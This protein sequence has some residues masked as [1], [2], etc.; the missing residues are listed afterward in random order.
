MSSIR[1]LKQRQRGPVE[2]SLVCLLFLLFSVCLIGTARHGTADDPPVSRNLERAQTFVEQG[3]FEQALPFLNASIRTLTSPEALYLRGHVLIK[4]GKT[5]A[6]KRDANTLIDEY[7]S[8]WRGYFLKAR[9]LLQSGSIDDQS[10]ELL[11]LLRKTVR[12]NPDHKRARKLMGRVYAALGR[13]KRALD[14]FEMVPERTRQSPRAGRMAARMAFLEGQD[15]RAADLARSVLTLVP[16]DPVAARIHSFVK[17]DVEPEVERRIRQL[18]GRRTNRS[19]DQWLSDVS[20]LIER[21]PQ[22]PHLLLFGSRTFLE[23]G[24]TD[25]ALELARRAEERGADAWTAFVLGNV[26]QKRT[27]YGTAAGWYLT[28]C[29]RRTPFGTARMRAGV[30]LS[31]DGAHE[32]AIKAFRRVFDQVALDE[33]ASERLVRSCQEAGYPV[34][35]LDRIEVLNLPSRKRETLRKQFED[36]LK[37]RREQEKE[38]LE[39]R[40]YQN[41]FY[42]IKL[43]LPDH[44]SYSL[45]AGRAQVVALFVSTSSQDRFFVVAER[46]LP[47]FDGRSTTPLKV[48][49]KLREY[50]ISTFLL[51]DTQLQFQR[52]KEHTTFDRPAVEY[53]FR[54]REGGQRMH[55]FVFFRGAWMYT[56]HYVARGK[57]NGSRKRMKEIMSRVIINDE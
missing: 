35:A 13:R 20:V 50:L 37:R 25:R 48:K 8:D 43:S 47:S 53:V 55:C 16:D 1:V 7:E 6:A 29:D 15:H 52:Q 17:R 44:W 10:E 18:E 56:F 46:R 33:Q 34:F 45:D 42:G 22:T 12:Y 21:Y 54:G 41:S 39:E 4:L 3:K 31:L 32:R 2:R 24:K 5:D 51:K 30:C 57:K 49:S 9:V 19:K 11:P 36:Q 40:V 26:Y 38:S 23:H 28:A 27:A 14:A